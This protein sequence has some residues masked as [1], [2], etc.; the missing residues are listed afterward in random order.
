MLLEIVKKCMSETPQSRPEVQDVLLQVQK[1]KSLTFN[2][3][4]IVLLYPNQYITLLVKR[5]SLEMEL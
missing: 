2:V 4:I 3:E 1:Q 5:C